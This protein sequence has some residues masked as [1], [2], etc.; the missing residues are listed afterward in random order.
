MRFI[1][2]QVRLLTPTMS[3]VMTS[4]ATLRVSPVALSSHT[5][6]CAAGR[7]QAIIVRISPTLYSRFCGRTINTGGSVT[8][9]GVYSLVRGADMTDKKLNV[10][11]LNTVKKLS[12]S[13]FAENII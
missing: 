1:A 6:R 13:M 4:C 9:M 7:D 11:T 12:L 3:D 2:K 5:Y 10:C 8:A